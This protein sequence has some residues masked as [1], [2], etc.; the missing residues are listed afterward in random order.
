LLV[1]GA[2]RRWA[3]AGQDVEQKVLDILERQ[4]EQSFPQGNS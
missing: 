4:V 3:A 1:P 2:A